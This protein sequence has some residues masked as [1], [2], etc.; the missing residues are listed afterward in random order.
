MVAYWMRQLKRIMLANPFCWTSRTGQDEVVK[1]HYS[2][3]EVSND[4][5]DTWPGYIVSVS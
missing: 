5:F 3:G 2:Y 4:L 1:V